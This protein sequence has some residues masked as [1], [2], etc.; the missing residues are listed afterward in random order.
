LIAFRLY[1]LSHFK[2]L[3]SMTGIKFFNSSRQINVRIGFRS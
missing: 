3:H 1:R 2:L